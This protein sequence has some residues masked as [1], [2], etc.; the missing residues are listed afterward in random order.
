MRRPGGLVPVNEDQDFL[1]D[2]NMKYPP[3]KHIIKREEVGGLD[4]IIEKLE[5][6]KR[7]IE[8]PQLYEFYGVLTP[9]GFMLSGPPGYGKTYIAKYLSYD[10]GARFMDIPLSKFESKWVGDAEK[11][12]VQI[13]D[14]ARMYKIVTGQ[15][16]LIFFDEA[17]EAFKDRRLMGW[18][19]PRVNSLLREMDG[20][21]VNNDGLF[22]GAATNHLD[23]V[24]PAI[25]RPGRLDYHLK[26]EEYSKYGLADVVRATELRL[27]RR[28]PNIDPY[29]ITDLEHMEIGTF[30]KDCNLTPAHINEA[31]KRAAD[32]KIKELI[33]DHEKI[34]RLDFLI[35]AEDIM[36][37]MY[38]MTG[39]NV[40]RLE[41][42]PIGFRTK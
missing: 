15:N 34:T 22:F 28:A 19:G 11:N 37:Q 41:R 35:Q 20:L 38:S 10:L 12:I 14:D 21:S 23:N 9:K 1:D 25:M 42:R 24:D 13:I 4:E 7:A 3:P 29:F 18:H 40:Q 36:K 2:F 31:F 39:R 16:V 27:N 17:E 6:F 32:A 8:F 30:A 33:D 26:I 5:T